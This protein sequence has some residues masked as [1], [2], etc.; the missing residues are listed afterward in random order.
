[1]NGTTEYKEIYK[2]PKFN[3]RQQEFLLKP[4]A[5]RKQAG[6]PEEIL[7]LIQ[8]VGKKRKILDLYDNKDT[9]LSISPDQIVVPDKT[10]YLTA[11]LSFTVQKEDG[12]FT[13]ENKMLDLY[14][15]GET[16]DEAEH[17]LYKEFDESY[18]LL[19]SIPDEELSDRLLRAKNVMNFFIKEII[20]E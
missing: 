9:I 7:G 10:Y 12:N 17:D 13:I 5:K 16:I 20:Y 6:E 19:N 3:K 15:A 2:L 14:A 18:K 1:V 11:P 4:I 8:R